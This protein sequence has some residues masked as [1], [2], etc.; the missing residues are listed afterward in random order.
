MDIP[1]Y[2]NSGQDFGLPSASGTRLATTGV[3]RRRAARKNPQ[4]SY[5]KGIVYKEG[6]N[7]RCACTEVDERPWD[8]PRYEHKSGM[9]MEIPG[10]KGSV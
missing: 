3:K 8:P 1:R 4:A 5:R 2:A 7:P 10:K 6:L 9:Y